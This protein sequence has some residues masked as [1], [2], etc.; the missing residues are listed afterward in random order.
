MRVG[1]DVSVFSGVRAGIARYLACVISEMMALDSDVE[2]V[3]YAPQP[4]HVPLPAGR[5]RSRIGSI[6]GSGRLGAWAQT[7]IPVWAAED[8]LDVFWGQN[9]G[10]PLRWRRRCFR[11]L[12]VHD[13][14]AWACPGA[15][16]LR[17]VVARRFYMPRACRVADAIIADSDSTARQ[18]LQFLGIRREKVTRVYLG[19][20]ARFQPVSAIA[21]QQLVA[22]KYGLRDDYIL[23]VG[24]IEPRKDH[25]VLLRALQKLPDAP[26]LVVVGGVGW[27]ARAIVNEMSAM[28]RVGR[29]KRLGFIVDADL[30]S[31]YGAAR[32]F[33]LPSY[34]EG[35]GLPVLEA[36]ACGCP[37][38]CSWSS[39]LPELGG[40][41]ARYFRVGDGEDLM[42]KLSV[43]LA[44]DRQ[45]A[46]M[47]TT[48][49][50]RAE[51]FSFR[52]AAQQI[53]G[54]MRRGVETRA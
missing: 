16:G 23:T 26:V 5:W 38:L 18:I 52:H 22:E 6:P 46:R 44:D 36:M 37:V 40:R 51:Q 1:V 3:L 29:V 11:L 35:F 17:S 13:L 27:K 32:M 4:V 49:L 20:D 53:L 50:V 21:A 43:L 48:G 25:L 7:Q 24:T 12:T 33:V 42:G 19:V 2:F 30:P 34:Y 31:L 15:M 9:H 45:R 28:E 41:A 54:T 39:S 8:D 10:M 14:A 47:S